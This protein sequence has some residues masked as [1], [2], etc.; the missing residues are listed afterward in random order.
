MP[1]LDLELSALF[2][3]NDSPVQQPRCADFTRF[4]DFFEKMDYGV[5]TASLQRDEDMTEIFI[6]GG[7]VVR[8]FRS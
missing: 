2:N 3:L 4:D 8:K 1:E 7:K 6:S 5:A